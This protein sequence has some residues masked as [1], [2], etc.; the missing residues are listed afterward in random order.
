MGFRIP[1]DGEGHSAF[2]PSFDL[3][4]IGGSFGGW[5]AD[6]YE[7]NYTLGGA[8]RGLLLLLLLLLDP[9]SPSQH[10][11]RID[12]DWRATPTCIS[13]FC[14]SGGPFATRE[15]IFNVHSLSLLAKSRRVVTDAVREGATRDG[16]SPAETPLSKGGKEF[17]VENVRDERYN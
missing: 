16:T 4:C 9:R 5:R 15:A 6:C 12:G 2:V 8:K 11:A 14:R 3:R 7:S 1:E 17:Q 10:I 13:R